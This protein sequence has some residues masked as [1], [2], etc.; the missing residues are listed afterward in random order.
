LENPA[1]VPLN[2]T[3]AEQA[4]IEARAVQGAD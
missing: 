2:L 3:V 1:G 4:A